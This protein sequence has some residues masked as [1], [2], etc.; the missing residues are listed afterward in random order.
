VKERNGRGGGVD[1]F[2]SVSPSCLKPPHDHS[3]AIGDC[4]SFLI[5]S[6]YAAESPIIGVIFHSLPLSKP[7]LK[8]GIGKGVRCAE[9]YF[10]IFESGKGFARK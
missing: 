3:P 7:T 2:K 4:L 8:Q 5:C 10:D 1:A 9:Y 6:R